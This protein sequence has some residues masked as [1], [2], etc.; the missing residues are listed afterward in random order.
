LLTL[1]EIADEIGVKYR[2]FIGCKN[3]FEDFVHGVPVGR[4]AKYPEDIVDFFRMVFALFDEGYSTEKVRNLLLNGVECEEDAFIESWLEEWRTSLQLNLADQEEMANPTDEGKDGPIDGP[5][6][7]LMGG[8]MDGPT[9]ERIKTKV[10]EQTNQAQQTLTLSLHAF[11]QS[12]T[13]TL[14]KM[15][16]QS[17]IA[18]TALCEVGADI[19]TAVLNLDARLSRLEN[20]LDVE[21]ADPMELY[22]VDA[23]DYQV[24]LPEI[25]MPDMKP[26][27]P[28]MAGEDA[29]EADDDDDLAAVRASI[30]NGIPDRK[31]LVDWAMQKR[32]EDEAFYSYSVLARM[33]N[34]SDVP[35][36]SGR[37]NWSRSTVRNLVARTVANRE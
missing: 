3:R 16:T 5:M 6:D 14:Q 26:A 7:G 32:Q 8:P 21:A 18:I 11:T 28:E 4:T 29:A 36:M 31:L 19:R 17:N 23:G 15:A 33:L 2:T 20:D 30:V 10:M 22:Q 25:A 35:T 24:D 1:K 37:N 27:A 12:L 13:Y 9:D 34:E